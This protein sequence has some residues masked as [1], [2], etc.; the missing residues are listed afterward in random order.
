[1]MYNPPKVFGL[2][3]NQSQVLSKKYITFGAARQPISAP[4]SRR[5]LCIA[6]TMKFLLDSGKKYSES[7]C[8]QMFVEPF[9]SQSEIGCPPV[10]ANRALYLIEPDYL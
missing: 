5:G 2:S 1:M 6:W 8:F 4:K 3:G 7:H 10:S 9:G